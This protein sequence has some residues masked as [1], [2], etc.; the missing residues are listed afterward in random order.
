MSEKQQ[1][2]TKLALME[3][4]RM[5]E[6]QAMMD[7]QRQMEVDAQ[8]KELM[9]QKQQLMALGDDLNADE[10]KVSVEGLDRCFPVR[11]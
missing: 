8:Q 9:M 10:I 2:M 1:M 4:Q 11:P 3:K 7:K 5:M 6:K